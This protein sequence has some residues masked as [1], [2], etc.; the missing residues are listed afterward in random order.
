[1]AS[2]NKGRSTSTS[3]GALRFET[4]QSGNGAPLHGP[5]A[6]LETHRSTLSLS[7]SYSVHLDDSSVY[8]GRDHD[9]GEW[10]YFEDDE[11][12]TP[13][14]EE[15]KVLDEVRDGFRNEKDLEGPPLQRKSTTRS[16]KDP[17]HV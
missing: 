11:Q 12:E 8:Y 1:M 14:E 9:S 7:R 3:Q 10:E 15:N 5:S 4:L 17:N 2:T 13:I 16:R 6:S